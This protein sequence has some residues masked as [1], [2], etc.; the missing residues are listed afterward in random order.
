VGYGQTH[1]FLCAH[2]PVD[3]SILSDELRAISFVHGIPQETDPVLLHSFQLQKLLPLLKYPLREAR[4][5]VQP[6]EAN[7]GPQKLL[8][9]AAIFVSGPLLHYMAF[10]ITL[11]S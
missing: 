11:V 9:T 6:S 2:I 5:E 8:S 10:H 3:V 7:F 4:F 1:C